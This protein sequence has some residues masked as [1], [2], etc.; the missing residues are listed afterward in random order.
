MTTRRNDV[1]AAA[2]IVAFE[3]GAVNIEA[4]SEAATRFAIQQW[5]LLNPHHDGVD[6]QEVVAILVEAE[7]QTERVRRFLGIPAAVR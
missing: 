2:K 5:C 3:S 7:V 4:R 6:H 1:I